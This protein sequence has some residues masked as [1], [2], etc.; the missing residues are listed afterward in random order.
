MGGLPFSEGKQRSKGLK[1]WGGNRRGG[2]G[3]YGWDLKK[4]KREEK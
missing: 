3:N 2:R 4:I 1:I